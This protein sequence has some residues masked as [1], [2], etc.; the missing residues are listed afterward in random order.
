MENKELL[1]ILSRNFGLEA[2]Q[3][4]LDTDSAYFKHIQKIL[5][6]KIKFFIRTDLDKL[7]QILYRID[8]PQSESD[9]AFEL[10]EINAIS[11]DLAEKIIF[12]QLKKIRYSKDFYSKDS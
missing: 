6:E 1:N 9:R 5:S 3:G 12:R 2:N 8:L 10:G 4:E 11:I 7:L